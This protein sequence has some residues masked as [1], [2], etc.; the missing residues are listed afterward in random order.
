MKDTTPTDEKQTGRAWL[1]TIALTLGL[2]VVIALMLFAFLAPSINSGP[3]DLPLAVAGP[4]AE[5]V[6]LEQALR[7][8]S[9]EGFA[10][11]RHLDAAG[12]REAVENREAIGGIVVEGPGDATYYT[13]SGNGA[14]YAELL[15]TI[16][17]GMQAQGQ[18][19]KV[20][21][22]A[23]LTEDD[24]GGTGL[25][26]LGLPLAFGGMASAAL[27]IVLLRGRTAQSLA[28]LTLISAVAGLVV[29]A[30]LQYGYDS[31]DTDYLVASLVIAAGIAATSFFVAGLGAFIGI[32][33]IGIGAILTIFIA[34]P[35]SGLTT[36]WWWL[37]EPWGAIG[38]GMPIGAA[39]HLLRSEAYFDGEG[40]GGS[41]TTLAI[42]IFMGAALIVGAALRKRGGNEPAPEEPTL[43][44]GDQDAGEE[45]STR[46]RLAHTGS[47]EGRGR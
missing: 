29:A 34:N 8:E 26:M 36:G 47:A 7:S 14:P 9:P 38:Q 44:D 22:L 25:A 42:W 11:E 35:L 39:G 12:V 5:V 30:I 6:A 18:S 24:P 41:W 2:P 1:T 40:A 45:T 13:A 27:V 28:G 31:F 20:V 32:R 4:A 15:G 19:A 16:S 43:E 33:A 17:A 46:R 3:K 37:P 10:F 21:E 23:P